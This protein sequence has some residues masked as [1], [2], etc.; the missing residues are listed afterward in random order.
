MK[1]NKNWSNF[2]KPNIINFPTLEDTLDKTNK[3]NKNKQNIKNIN[4]IFPNDMTNDIKESL[5]CPIEQEIALTPMITNCNHIFN[6]TGIEKWIETGNHGCPICRQDIYS[7]EKVEKV[8]KD[9]DFMKN[10]NLIKIKYDN[11][12]YSYNNFMKKK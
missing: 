10:L 8:A 4:I 9:C 11:K 1:S 3:T 7:I 12:I 6:K 5:Y 2:T